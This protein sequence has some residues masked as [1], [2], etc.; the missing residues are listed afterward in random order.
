[1][2]NIEK[3]LEKY[4]EGKGPKVRNKVLYENESKTPDELISILFRLIKENLD[5]YT[6]EIS[7]IEKSIELLQCISTIIENKDKVNRKI[8]TRK[9]HKLD[10]NIDR[11]KIEKKNTFANYK[12][13]CKKLER[14]R[15]NIE[16]VQELINNSETKN[17]TFLKYLIEEIRSVDYLE[18]TLCRMPE[19]VN[20][21]VK[22]GNTLL[23]TVIDSYLDSIKKADEEK[24][25]YYS[26]IVSL[27]LVQK[28]LRLNSKD[29]RRIIDNLYKGKDS[30]S[31]TKRSVKENKEKIQWLNN[32]IS[33]I[34]NFDVE[35]KNIKN[36]ASRYRIPIDFDK[37]VKE[38][39]KLTKIPTI[40][41]E[42][43]YFIDDYVI[44]IDREGISEIDDALSC[45]K[46]KNGN[47]LLGV[48]IASILGYFPYDSNIVDTA[49]SRTKTIYLP[50]RYTNDKGETTKLIPI[51][52]L[53]F[54]TDKASLLEGQPRYTRSYYFEIDNEGNVVNEQFLKTIIKN[55]KNT[56]YQEINNIL[57]KGFEDK[58]LEETVMNLQHISELLEKSYSPTE[59][60]ENIKENTEDYSELRVKR[61]G[62]EKIVYQAMLLTG[63]KVANYFAN[64]KEGYPCI[65]RVH[66][67]NEENNS[68]MRAMIENLTKTYGGDQY[69][70]LYHLL[71]GIYPK[72][73]YGM[74]GGHQGLGLEHYCHCTSGLRR[75]AD[76][77]VEHALEVC[78][79][80]NPTDKELACLESEIKKR[81]LEINSKLEPI[82]WFVK[83]YKQAYQKKRR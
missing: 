43:R 79:D 5:A 17:Y 72:G 21:K 2:K 68:K 55:D 54:S 61:V 65:Y 33:V 29:K 64:S 41:E 14:V 16:S 52:P 80:N 50:K 36:I 47:Y 23:E 53:E 26:K 25:L 22:N 24:I 82:D 69:K 13:A 20:I 35:E 28:S 11:I 74:E 77:V 42:D 63:N 31:I 58:K 71:E 73:W 78:F 39:A 62:A 27:I 12:D 57:E 40:T 34:K 38:E 3:A 67:E 46:L 10:E 76:I 56:S 15:E 45:K 19:L 48:H 9:L 59:L 7:L 8:V 37:V 1:M 49:I 32:L 44:T 75:G 51:F 66:Q 83:D 4:A 70:K 81:T 60:Y 6:G 30:L 18:Y